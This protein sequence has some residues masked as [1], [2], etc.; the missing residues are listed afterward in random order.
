M[1]TAILSNY[2]RPVKRP[3]AR[4]HQIPDRDLLI[5]RLLW[6]ME[7]Q[8]NGCWYWT[9]SQDGVGY[10]HVGLTGKMVGA[11]RLSFELFVGPIPDGI[12][13]CHKCDTR[14]CI[15]PDHLFKGT[16][17]ENSYDMCQKGRSAFGERH[18]QAKL[19]EESVLSI[20]E[21]WSSGKL[22]QRKIAKLFG[23]TQSVVSMIVSGKIWK[24]L[25]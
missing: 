16:K 5:S 7:V 18:S 15:N 4:P 24:K 2:V 22:S 9:G 6:W 11:H 12:C 23:I 19:T 13:I 20:R 3:I 14:K 1:A 8:P 17:K 25:R 10:G 21:M